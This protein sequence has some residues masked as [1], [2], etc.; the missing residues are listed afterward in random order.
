[1]KK[2]ESVFFKGQE[3]EVVSEDE[4]LQGSYFEATILTVSRLKKKKKKYLVEYKTLRDEGNE[5]KPLIEYV[6]WSCLRPLP[7]KMSTRKFV[8]NEEVDAFANDG[9]WKGMVSKVIS[10]G[11]RYSVVFEASEEEMEYDLSELRYHFEWIDGKWVGDGN[12]GMS[13]IAQNEE[14]FQSISPTGSFAFTTHMNI[15]TTQSGVR[16]AFWEVSPSRNIRQ[17][18]EN[19]ATPNKTDSPSLPVHSIQKNRKRSTSES[20]AEILGPSKKVREGE[21]V[22]NPICIEDNYERGT[23]IGSPTD[24]QYGISSPITQDEINGTEA[25][26]CEVNNLP[27]PHEL[28]DGEPTGQTKEPLCSTEMTVFTQTEENFQSP[29]TTGSVTLSTD[30]DIAHSEAGNNFWERPSSRKVCQRIGIESNPK[31]IDSPSLSVLLVQE[32]MK[33]SAPES[34]AVSRPSEKLRE[35]AT[36]VPTC[37]EDIQERTISIGNC[38]DA[39]YGISS[40][41]TQGERNGTEAEVCEVNSLP[42]PHV[43]LLKKLPDVEPAGLTK[44]PLGGTAEVE[45]LAVN[46]DS[47]NAENVALISKGNQLTENSEKMRLENASLMEMSVF[48][49]NEESFQS[50]SITGSFALS[51]NMEISHTLSGAGNSLWE[52]PSSRKVC[53][54][55]GIGSSLK[56]IDSP[57]LSILPVQESTK[58]SVPESHAEVSRPSENLRE[59]AT[60]VP[61]YVE[62]SH[63]RGTSSGIHTNSQNGISSPITQGE[64]SKCRERSQGLEV[65][66]ASKGIIDALIDSTHTL[67]SN[68]AEEHFPHSLL[69]EKSSSHTVKGIAIGGLEVESASKGIIDAL[70]DSPPL[71]SSL[72][73]ESASKG[74]VDALIG[75]TPIF[76]SNS[77]EEYLPLSMFLEKSSSHTVKDIA[78]EGLEVESARIIDALIDSTPILSS[79]SAVEQLPL[80]MLLEKSCSHT[81]K[82]IAIGGLEVESA[83]KGII[84]APIDSAPIFLSNSEEEHLP[85]SMFLEKS[86]LHTVKDIAIGGVLNK[87]VVNVVKEKDGQPQVSSK[88]TSVRDVEPECEAASN[89]MEVVQ[90]ESTQSFSHTAEEH[91]LFSVCHEKMNSRTVN[92]N[93]E[94]SPCSQLML[95]E[96]ITMGEASMESFVFR[97][98][99]NVI[100]SSFYEEYTTLDDSGR[101]DEVTLSSLEIGPNTF[102]SP[103]RQNEEPLPLHSGSLPFIKSSDLWETVESAEVFRLMPQQPH[104][105]PLEQYDEDL[106]EGYAIGLTWSLAKLVES[107]SK[108]KL[109]EPRDVFENKLKALADLED[110]GFTIEKI[111]ARLEVVLE[112]KDRYSQLHDMSKT[113]ETEVIEEKRKL[114]QLNFNLHRL[115]TEREM[116]GSKVAELR[117]TL[118]AIKESIRVGKLK[119]DCVVDTA[120]VGTHTN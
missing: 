104:F 70:I 74:I 111:R 62:D 31:E 50:P 63:E 88:E 40:L 21:T 35:G 117:R 107:I 2:G 73:V 27:Q 55:I 84:D 37:I 56:G 10:G 20:H 72:E 92:D 86:S 102:S 33:Q 115:E 30:N 57:S 80:S 90:I 83:R 118:D 85:L 34:H 36:K 112:I 7:P 53:Q 15:S 60:K 77:A 32:N 26:V 113:V 87:Q 69:L 48:A 38:I 114:N 6:H 9:W 108:A 109:D 105:R 25:E 67:S 89:E 51:T 82:D 75:S 61:T 101:E 110:F 59:G 19:K 96:A 39:Q 12:Q 44:E 49:R 54:R 64:R 46:L 99:S 8:T 29:Y 42:Q 120:L 100:R 97:E 14:S 103:R 11:L 71:L 91:Q 76:S 23:S 106:R 65:E 24:S 58:Q 93:R 45:E 81:V 78:I 79:N 13:V 98:S 18:M 66:S 22:N 17:R 4:G 5:L 41:I 28:H 52:M 119:F 16:E 68:S 47:L 1:M 116:R 94:P 95:Y 3:V 43:Q